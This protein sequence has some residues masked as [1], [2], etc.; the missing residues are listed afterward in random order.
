[1]LLKNRS[2]RDWIELFSLSVYEISV[3]RLQSFW[4]SILKSIDNLIA[5]SADEIVEINDFGE[6][7]AKSVVDYFADDTNIELVEKLRRCG[8]AMEFSENIEDLRFEGKLSF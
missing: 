8:V 1:M 2:L 5:A 6:I 4:Q 7:S 3:K